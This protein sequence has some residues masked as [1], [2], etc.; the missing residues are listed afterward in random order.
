MNWFYAL[1]V[2]IVIGLV[3]L[4]SGCLGTNPIYDTKKFI[5]F[6]KYLKDSFSKL[7][8]DTTKVYEM[9]AGQICGI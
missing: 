2:V 5:D 1:M 7:L 4:S 9:N 3:V 6:L 8:G